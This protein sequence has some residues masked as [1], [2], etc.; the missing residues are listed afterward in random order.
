MS[1]ELRTPIRLNIFSQLLFSNFASG[2]KI[3]LYVGWIERMPPKQKKGPKQ[4]Q[5]P[6]KNFK[7]TIVCRGYGNFSSKGK[8]WSSRCAAAV[9][10]AKLMLPPNTYFNRERDADK[11]QVRI[12]HRFGQKPKEVVGA[13]FAKPYFRKKELKRMEHNVKNIFLTRAEKR[14]A[15]DREFANGKHTATDVELLTEEQVRTLRP[16]VQELCERCYQSVVPCNRIVEVLEGVFIRVNEAYLRRAKQMKKI[17]EDVC[18]NGF[19]HQKG[20]RVLYHQTDNK[21]ADKII[22]SQIMIRGPAGLFGAGIYF[23]AT[24]KETTLKAHKQGVILQCV[25]YLGKVKEVQAPDPQMTFS[26]LLKQKYDSL[27]GKNGNS[28]LHSGDEYVEYNKDQVL[29]IKLYSSENGK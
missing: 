21:A 23:A 19:N 22:D 1:T 5:F 3:H 9:F 29:S 27:V 12:V 28:F 13:S 14:L 6:E 11:V 2:I 24:A 17:Q 20:C 16:H 26:T 8:T 10:E 4:P 25:V 15:G 7:Q 18:R